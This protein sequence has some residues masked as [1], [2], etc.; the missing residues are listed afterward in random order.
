MERFPTIWSENHSKEN[1]R[2]E[3]P[4]FSMF[5]L[6]K[7]TADQYPNNI[8]LE[9]QDKQTTFSEM[10]EQIEL[11]AQ[12]LLACGVKKGDFISV[13]APNSPQALISVYAANRIGAVANM[14]H[15]LLSVNEIKRFVEHVD[16]K[17]VVTFDNL[18]E[19]ISGVKWET[20]ENP[21]LILARV[22]DALPETV[23]PYYLAANK[24]EISINPEHNAIYW[25]DFLAKGKQ[26]EEVLPAD[27][28]KGE[29]LAAILYSG[30]TTGI[31]KGVMIHNQG[32]NCM[33]IQTGEVIRSDKKDMAGK[34]LLALMPVFHGFGLAMCM[35]VALYWGCHIFLVPKFDFNACAKLI[36][37]KKI[38][39]IYAVPAL[40]EALSRT[41]E[42]E[43]EDLSFIEMVAF[44]GDKCNEKLYNR[45]NNYLKKGGSTE[46]MTE[47][48]GLTECL[49]AA[50]ISPFFAHKKGSTGLPLPGNTIKICEFGTTKEAPLGEDGEV[51]INGPTLMRGYYKNEA[52]TKVALREHE[53]GRIWL[54]TGDIGAM[55]EDGYLY[56]RQ[57]HSKMIITSGYNIYP[58]QIEEVIN[59]CNGVVQSCVVG[60]EDRSVGQ[61]IVA[62]VQPV[63]MN[64]DLDTLRQRILEECTKNV[65]EYA[66]PREVIFREALP[67]TA[68]GKVSFKALTAELNEKEK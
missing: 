36:F 63:N 2:N 62:V 35:H 38:N 67:R 57:R 49:S 61:R 28:G 16:S 5:S 24:V 55:D 58:S 17:A 22:V 39:H 21:V 9:F 4:E 56:Y 34:K 3:F 26:R 66:M 19:K 42:I 15:P 23:Q 64:G 54:H 13:I 30:G 48:Y 51:C 25:N 52:E 33:A 44:S 60:V 29:D 6:L 45:M 46:Q 43:T 59:S 65:A 50:C 11:V 68:M 41:E 1:F 7:E 40:F 20:T 27:N 47:A 31:P 12:S 32:F 14:I 10:I 18:Y 37:D 8:A 53:D